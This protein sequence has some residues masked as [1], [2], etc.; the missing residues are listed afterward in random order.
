MKRTINPQKTIENILTVSE[1]LFLEKGYEKTTTQEIVNQTGLS[2]GTLF[3]HF[4]TKDD[5]LAAVLDKHNDWTAQEMYKW[6]KEIEHHTAREKISYLFHRFYDDVDRT[7]LSKIALLS[8]SPKLIIEDLR[9]WANNI[10]PIITKLISEGNQ[11]G[12]IQTDYPQESAQLFN[13]LFCIWCDPVILSCDAPSL[14]KRLQFIQHTMKLLGVDIVDDNFIEKTMKFADGLYP[15]L[16]ET[17]KTS[18]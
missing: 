5:I 12:S 11:D 10:S 17:S 9:G 3:H 14:R 8:K 6:L 15:V 18:K 2:K 4:K 16:E 1:R 13:L 7:P